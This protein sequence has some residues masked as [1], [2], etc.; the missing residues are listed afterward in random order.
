M[1]WAVFLVHLAHRFPGSVQVLLTDLSTL[2]RMDDL[3]SFGAELGWVGCLKP[4]RHIIGLFR[5]IQHDKENRLLPQ[6][7]QLFAVL[8]PPLDT[9]G[10]ISAIFHAGMLGL[11]IVNIC[12]A[13]HRPLH[14]AV[15]DGL[16]EG[17]VRY[18]PGENRALLKARRCREIQLS[19][20]WGF[21]MQSANDPVPLVFF[22]MRE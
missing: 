15:N 2:I 3:S 22:I 21:A 11:S 16:L 8:A 17:V 20:D 10:Q 9:G 1:D 19:A 7:L 4:I 13:L 6:G 12:H 5:A 18:C 14:N